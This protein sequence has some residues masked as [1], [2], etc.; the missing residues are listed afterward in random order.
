MRIEKR[1]SVGL[2]VY[3]FACDLGNAVG[4]CCPPSSV[5]CCLCGFQQKVKRGGRHTR[6]GP[7]SPECCAV[8]GTDDLMEERGE[9]PGDGG[10]EAIGSMPDMCNQ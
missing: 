2:G 9:R 1:V 3:V 5:S 6:E 10:L 8:L 7:F 4:L